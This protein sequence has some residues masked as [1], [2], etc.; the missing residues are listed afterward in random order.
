MTHIQ[1]HDPYRDSIAQAKVN[2]LDL[3]S[4]I[5]IISKLFKSINFCDVQRITSVFIAKQNNF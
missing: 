1:T 5:E 4:I 3:K 2:Y